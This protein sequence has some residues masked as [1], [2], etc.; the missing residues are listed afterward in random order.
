MPKISVLLW[1]YN[2]E[3]YIRECIESILAQTLRPYEIVVCDDHSTDDSWKIISEYS[4]RYPELINAHRHEKNMGPGFNSRFGRKIARGDLFTVID[5][6]DRFLPRKLELEWKAL[7]EH[8][9]AKIAYSNV[10]TIDVEG[11]RTGI[12]SEGMGPAPPGGDVFIEVFSR[13]IYRNYL[14]YRAALKEIGYTDSNLCGCWDWDE[15]IRLA[16]RFTVVYSGEALLEYRVHPGGLS[17]RNPEEVCK[18][19]IE[20]YE[21]NLPLLTQK[22]NAEI[23]RVKC[24]VENRVAS[25]IESLLFKQRQ[26]ILTS[27]ERLNYYSG[28]N[29]YD[30]NC[31]LFDQLPEYDR[32]VLKKELSPLFKLLVTQIIL[33]GIERGNRKL[34]FKYMFKSLWRDPTSFDIK[35]I[36]RL[37]LPKQVHKWLRTVYYIFRNAR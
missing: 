12:W 9:E 16:A 22:S 2:F 18:A 23:L 1:S 26:F 5:G 8:P 35:L 31:K 3:K 17:R 14:C 15:M 25:N 4:Q 7:Q 13:R 34:A 10:Y 6:D 24:N 29:V 33:G 11:N 19:L 30:R 32:E 36:A 28:R 27:P 21:K 20:V 37:L